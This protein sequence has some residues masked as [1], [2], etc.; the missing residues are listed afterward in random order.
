M[1]IDEFKPYRRSGVTLMRPYVKGE[2]LTGVSVNEV[3]NPDR[4]G[5]YIAMNP[6]NHA[7]KWFVAQA[8]FDKQGFALAE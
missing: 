6:A 1:S 4:D 5:G 3:D 8:F 7:D 2:D